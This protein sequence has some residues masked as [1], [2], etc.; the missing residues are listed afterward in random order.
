[1][2]NCFLDELIRKNGKKHKLSED[3]GVL[4]GFKKSPVHDRKFVKFVI[5]HKS[6]SYW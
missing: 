3:N 5:R 1:M 4:H 2:T 6:I